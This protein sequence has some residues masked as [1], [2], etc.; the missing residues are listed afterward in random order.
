MTKNS[1]VAEVTFNEEIANVKQENARFFYYSSQGQVFHQ[2]SK[3][4]LVQSQ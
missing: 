2:P 4:L 1:F 3:H